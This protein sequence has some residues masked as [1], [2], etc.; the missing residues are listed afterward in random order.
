[1]A[2]SPRDY[3]VLERAVARGG[4]LQLT[5]NG[6]QWII[7]AQ[8]LLVLEGRE[9]LEARHPSTGESMRFF[10]DEIERIEAIR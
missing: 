8:R 7:L 10:V 1:M 6:S 9:A 4:R 5:R 2:F 3:D